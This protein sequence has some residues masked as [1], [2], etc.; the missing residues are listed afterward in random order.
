MLWLQEILLEP[1]LILLYAISL[2][3]GEPSVRNK[4]GAGL[5]GSINELSLLWYRH[6]VENRKFRKQAS[7]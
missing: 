2:G 1:G 3:L 6:D 7:P 5:K 4:H